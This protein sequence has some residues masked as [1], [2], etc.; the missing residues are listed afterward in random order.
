[1]KA[2]SSFS[3]CS[4]MFLYHLT[5]SFT[6]QSILSHQDTNL[7]IG[8]CMND[9]EW[10]Y[11]LVLGPSIHRDHLY[12][13]TQAPA[14]LHTIYPWLLSQATWLLV[15]HLVYEYYTS[16]DKI[17][18]LYLPHD[19]AKLITKA[20]HSQV[21][22]K[23]HYRPI[24]SKQGHLQINSQT[25]PGQQLIIMP[26]QRS[27]VNYI[28]TRWLDTKHILTS[29]HTLNQ[30]VSRFWNLK[31]WLNTQLICTPGEC[32]RD[33]RQLSQ[34]VV[35]DSHKW[36]YKSQQDPRYDIMRV[37]ELMAHYYWCQLLTNT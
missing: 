23:P 26:D 30:D 33:Y 4:P 18:N 5:H 2:L 28:T 10:N 20:P 35:I 9:Q 31:Y 6:N 12:N 14:Q 24:T 16:Y 3:T 36:Y 21:K 19:I 17:I 8:D 32:F 27:I 1:M 22:S 15:H 37:C 25:Q 7:H 13:I 11:Y 34:I 29:Q